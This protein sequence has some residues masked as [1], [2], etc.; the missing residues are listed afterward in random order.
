L[1]LV[2]ALAIA[3]IFL[4]FFAAMLIAMP[5]SPGS[6]GV[7][8]C[9]MEALRVNALEAVEDDEPLLPEFGGDECLTPTIP[10]V[11]VPNDDF[12]AVP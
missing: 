4:S 5:S 11:A 2:F 10:T 9:R 1:R 8:L 6:Y 12:A 3:T 7:A